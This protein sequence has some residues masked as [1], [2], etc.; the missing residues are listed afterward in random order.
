M[1][2]DIN[3]DQF[4][5]LILGGNFSAAK[6][7]IGSYMSNAL[8]VLTQNKDHS[9]SAMPYQKINSSEIRAIKMITIKGQKAL[10]VGANNQKVEILTY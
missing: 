10:A 6:P 2:L 9:Y 8:T 1:P 4:T 7:E 5:D 3:H